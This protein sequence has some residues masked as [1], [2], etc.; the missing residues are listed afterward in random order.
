V[1]ERSRIVIVGLI[2]IAS[3][4]MVLSDRFEPRSPERLLDVAGAT[5]DQIPLSG[6]NVAYLQTIDLHQMQMDQLVG[7][8]DRRSKEKGFYYP[9][10]NQDFSPFFKRLPFTEVR[11]RYQTQ[12]PSDAVFIINASFFEDYQP[13][14]QLSFPIKHNGKVITA[15][16]S[17]YGPIQKPADPYYRKIQLNALI[18][19]RK[20]AA[21]ETYNPANGYPLNR[22]NVKNA[23]VSYAYR[24]HPAY[25]LAGDPENLYHVLGVLNSTEF[26]SRLLIVTVNRSTLE[27]AATILR[28]HGANGNLMTIDGGI[29]TYL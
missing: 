9:V 1:N 17:P 23:L 2:A 29:S 4:T 8:A 22:G 20:K 27:Q 10:K 21:I 6:N 13:Q 28:Q 16:S 19:D 25:A 12:Y 14:T 26:T 7:E 5:L 24:D 11:D 18:W 3:L 15:G